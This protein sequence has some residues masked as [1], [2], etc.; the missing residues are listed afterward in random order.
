MRVIRVSEGHYINIDTI[1]LID[2]DTPPYIK[3]VVNGIRIYELEYMKENY[4][5]FC[6]KL[7]EKIVDDEVKIVDLKD[8]EKEVNLL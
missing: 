2:F 1:W 6:K 8:I 4:D 7:V 5:K 3:I